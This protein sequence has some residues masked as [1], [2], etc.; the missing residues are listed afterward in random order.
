MRFDKYGHRNKRKK[1]I[2]LFLILLLVI[3]MVVIR[4]VF[5]TPYFRIKE[6]RVRGEDSIAES[7]ILKWADIPLQKCIFEINLR[8]I[9]QRIELRPRVKRAEVRRSFPSTIIIEVEERQPFVYLLCDNSLW[10][11]DKEG[12]V[13]GKVNDR[14][15]LP[16]ITGTSLPYQRE[17]INLGIEII[18]V[19]KGA[20]LSFSKINV[21]GKGKI[22][23]YLKTGIKVYLGKVEH[24]EY[25]SYL[26]FITVDLKDK[27]R[28]IS[29]IDLRFDGQ[30][31][32]GLK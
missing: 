7:I 25:F 24:L 32:I 9:S 30:V 27:K 17:R 2:F 28:E 8:K 3:G 22:V 10:E 12:V 31:V 4:Y 5:T 20:G 13:L 18:K 26:P 16:V 15:D 11:V 21:R 29:Y 6:V 1:G 14:Q 23:G 19:G